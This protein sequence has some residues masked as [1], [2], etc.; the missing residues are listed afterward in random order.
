MTGKRFS[1]GG[2][3]RRDP[4]RRRARILAGALSLALAATGCR[5]APGPASVSESAPPDLRRRVEASL[6]LRYEAQNTVLIK[7]KPHWWWPAVRLTALGYMRVDRQTSSY[8]VA[9]LTPVGVKLFDIARTNGHVHADL[10]VSSIPHREEII[11]AMGDEIGRMLFDL[12]PA[13]DA[14]CRREGPSL[15]FRQT[16]T[17]VVV[18]HVIAV[19]ECR[20]VE[21]RYDEGR[22]RVCTVWYRD[23]RP[24]D[25]LWF[26][27][28]IVLQNHRYGFRLTLRLREVRE[29]GQR[30]LSSA[31]NRAIFRRLKE[32]LAPGAAFTLYMPG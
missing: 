11:R 14:V 8:A 12:V 25:G 17:N 29:D 7:I 30:P 26:P 19:P 6:P 32:T 18:E 28:E 27:G 23:Y 5:T 2:P 20:L 3:D 10:L 31:V 9:C 4:G 13:P 1:P 24:F 22:R 15:V 21:K 16:G